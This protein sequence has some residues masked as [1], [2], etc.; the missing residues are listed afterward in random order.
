[1]RA[2]R[3]EV[4][5]CTPGEP[6]SRHRNKSGWPG[7]VRKHRPGPVSDKKPRHSDTIPN[8]T[9]PLRKRVTGAS[10]DLRVTMRSCLAPACPECLAA[11]TCPSHPSDYL[12]SDF[13]DSDSRGTNEGG[14]AEADFVAVG[15]V[16]HVPHE[17]DELSPDD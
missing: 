3:L 9:S 10:P 7:R 5:F 13:S 14:E 12:P 8:A 6:R 1:M 17:R 11:R 2:P 15:Q 16:P 4:T